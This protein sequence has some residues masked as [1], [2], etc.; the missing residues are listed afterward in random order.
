[1]YSKEKIKSLEELVQ[2]RHTFSNQKVV[3]TNGCFDI[4]HAGHVLYLEEAKK[5]GDILILG[6]NSDAS[7][8]RLKGNSRP[9]NNQTD[10]AIVLAGLSS[11]D[12]V[13]IFDQDDPYDLI[14]AIQPDVLVKGGDWKIEQIIGSDIVK[15]R[16]GE[17]L[18]LSFIEGKSTTKI[19]D[20][21]VSNNG[22]S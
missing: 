18:S 9:I 8:K 11:V 3:F 21:V 20:K 15:R 13:V 4:I 5:C 10:R 19:I 6:L 2:L 7:V 14:S 22:T 16:G 12:Y 17:V 1:M